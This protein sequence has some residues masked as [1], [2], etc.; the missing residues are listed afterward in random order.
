[1][2]RPRFTIASILF[3][4]LFVAV[5]VAAL[6]ASDNP[7]D[8]GIFGFTLLSLLT[9]VLLAAH[10][11]E[12]RRA[13]WIGF[14]LFGW[15]YLG[16]SLIPSVNDRLPTSKALAFLE[17][18]RP[19]TGGALGSGLAFVDFDQDG[20]LDLFV[21]AGAQT[22]GV[23]V[24]DGDGFFRTVKPAA[25]QTS[26]G[27]LLSRLDATWFTGTRLVLAAPSGT[28][29]NFV[30]IGH[31]IFALMM[32]ILGG[33]LSR[34]IRSRERSRSKDEGPNRGNPSTPQAETP[35]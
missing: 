7:W 10:R 29:E 19:R 23:F 8:R 2:R 5:A 17:T 32:A 1:M 22:P 15:I 27:Q 30:R 14:A 21:T 6:R 24:S 28:R 25:A 4:V 9:A 33:T 12:G 35:Q 20:A 13:F 3:I 11:T 18:K 26:G 16:A 31:S 34:S